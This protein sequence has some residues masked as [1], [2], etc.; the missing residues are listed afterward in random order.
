MVNI[1]KIQVIPANISD[2]PI[3]QNMARFY[4][5]ELSRYCSSPSNDLNES[6]DFKNYFEEPSR[7]AYII[8]TEDDELV[9]FALINKEG[10]LNDTEYNMGEFFIL[11]KFQGKG[12]GKF[13]LSKI[14]QLHPGKW[15]I[16]VIPEN[17]PALIFWRKTV[18]KLT[19]DSYKEEIKNIDYD[20]QQPKRY[21]LSFCL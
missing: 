20:K 8:K 11:A 5:N 21:I 6:F 17:K 15:E 14:F 1:N 18:S 4:M 12:I 10:T 2:Y 3:I 9:G 13:V 16:S 7:K 19:R